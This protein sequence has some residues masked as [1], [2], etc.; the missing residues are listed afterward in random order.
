MWRTDIS[1]LG[2]R[3]RKDR[4]AKCAGIRCTKK[5]F[6]ACFSLVKSVPGK[7]ETVNRAS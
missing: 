3:P 5:F 6:S 2:G 1:Q 4:V 7:L